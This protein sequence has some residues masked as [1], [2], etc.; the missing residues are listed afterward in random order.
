VQESGEVLGA[1]PRQRACVVVDQECLNSVLEWDGRDDEFDMFGVTFVELL[2]RYDEGG[3]DEDDS[4]EEEEDR[5]EGDDEEGDE[6]AE[7]DRVS[8]TRVGISFLVPRVYSMLDLP[9]WHSFADPDGG[10]VTP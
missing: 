4:D 1:S 9:G 5:E 2:S 10:V 8:T 3:G 7:K 6:K